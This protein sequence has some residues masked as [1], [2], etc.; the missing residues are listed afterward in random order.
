L[1]LLA[2]TEQGISLEEVLIQIGLSR[3]LEWKY[4]KKFREKYMQMGKIDSAQNK[5]IL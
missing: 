5:G 2:R 3:Q 1:G 4:T